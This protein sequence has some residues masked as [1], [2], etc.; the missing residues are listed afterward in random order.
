MNQQSS[1]MLEAIQTPCVLEAF[2]ARRKDKVQKLIDA[3]PA[4]IECEQHGTL[5]RVDHGKSYVSVR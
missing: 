2:F 1:T 5:L 3:K 4:S